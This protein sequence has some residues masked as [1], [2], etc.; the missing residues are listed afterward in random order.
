MNNPDIG[1]RTV[2][3]GGG[4]LAV[5]TVLSACV[6]QQPATVEQSAPAEQPKT[7][8]APPATQPGEPAS[9]PAADALANANDV[10]AGG[11]V[12]LKDQQMVITRDDG[13]TP[14]A[15]SAVCTH[16][17]CLVTSVGNGTIDCRCHGSKFDAATGDPVKGPAKK[18]L[19]GVAV[20]E[21]DGSIFQ[22]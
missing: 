19:P 16:Q 13:G 3:L 15:F 14:H 12:I 7:S 20:V 11:G 5:G 18:P 8:A 22:A 9:E 6:V 10:P 17:G 2:V 21:R 1:R 4:T